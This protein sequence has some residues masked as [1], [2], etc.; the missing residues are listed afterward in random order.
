MDDH[1]CA[2]LGDDATGQRTGKKQGL[3]EESLG[4]REKDQGVWMRTRLG[5]RE[6]S[7]CGGQ[8]N[9]WMREWGLFAS[10]YTN[11]VCA[12]ANGFAGL[13]LLNNVGHTHPFTQICRNHDS[14]NGNVN[15]N[16]LDPRE[17]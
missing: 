5:E 14:Q 4:G 7:L 11:C 6:S 10:P 2:G 8:A 12:P 15:A 9:G 1:K 17:L 13:L 16:F 3:S